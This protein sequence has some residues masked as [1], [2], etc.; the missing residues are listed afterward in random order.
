MNELDDLIPDADL[1][2]LR[3]RIDG[4]IDARVRRRRLGAGL[5]AGA[6]VVL[7]ATAVLTVPGARP[8]VT[9]VGAS[10][11]VPAR[12]PLSGTWAPCPAT[13]TVPSPTDVVTPTA[14]VTPPAVVP[15]RTVPSAVPVPSPSPV[16]VSSPSPSPIG[17][18]TSATALPCGPD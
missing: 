17:V 14:A 1:S 5:G 6:A 2:A 10:Q 8:P 12:E 4:A 9:S 7:V 18:P 16:P 11:T 3:R 15:S 13:G